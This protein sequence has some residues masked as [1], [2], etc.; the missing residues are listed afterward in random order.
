MT[1]SGFV[2]R[3]GNIALHDPSRRDAWAH[4][5][6]DQTLSVP[7]SQGDYA[8]SYAVSWLTACEVVLTNSHRIFARYVAKRCTARQI[9]E[10][11]QR[12]PRINADRIFRISQGRDNREARQILKQG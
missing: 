6:S 2:R 3:V 9:A 11:S 7:S 1:I 4:E 12:M 5:A 8:N 10:L